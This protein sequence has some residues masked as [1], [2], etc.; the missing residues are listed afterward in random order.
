MMS[1]DNVSKYAALAERRALEVVSDECV[2]A[3]R[4][5]GLTR[6]EAV[7]FTEKLSERM[8]D[9][10]ALIREYRDF[11]YAAQI[12]F[13]R[14]ATPVNFVSG[15]LYDGTVYNTLGMGIITQA[16]YDMVK[17]AYR[18]G[19]TRREAKMA[20]Y[21]VRKYELDCVITDRTPNYYGE[22]TEKL[23]TARL[24]AKHAGSLLSLHQVT[25]MRGGPAVPNPCGLAKLL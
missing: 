24:L 4:K 21:D 20:G 15:W 12:H 14:T 2:M 7:S 6:Q 13:S 19:R 16:G 8:L 17:A 25:K 3:C 1:E 9:T 23:K 22:L 5:M 11:G 10:A 18:R